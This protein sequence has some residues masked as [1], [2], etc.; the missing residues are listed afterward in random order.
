MKIIS[1]NNIQFTL[2]QN[3]QDNWNILEQLEK[4]NNNYMVIFLFV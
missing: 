4:I 1:Y 2:G 3:A